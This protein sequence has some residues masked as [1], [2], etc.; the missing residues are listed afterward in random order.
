[1]DYRISFR[2]A[3]Y[4][5]SGVKERKIYSKKEFQSK[6]I[7]MSGSVNERLQL[8]IILFQIFSEKE[9]SL[10]LIEYAHGNK[11]ELESIQDRERLNGFFL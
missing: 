8:K 1:M 2:S 11:K 5:L 10:S 6:K 7:K 9:R 4:F 3:R